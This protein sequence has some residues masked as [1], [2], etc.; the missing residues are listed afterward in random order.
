MHNLQLQEKLAGR[1]VNKVYRINMCIIQ[2][3]IISFVMEKCAC[4][5]GGICSVPRQVCD[6]REAPQKCVTHSQESIA[7][8]LH[9]QLNS[10]GWLKCFTGD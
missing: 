6:L 1:R 9:G 8:R 5:D 2:T 4:V 3:D 7:E 10:A